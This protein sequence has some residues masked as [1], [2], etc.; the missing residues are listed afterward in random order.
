MG[1]T[2]HR[3]VV[4]SERGRALERR[5]ARCAIA[6]LWVG[7]AT[8]SSGCF[9]EASA[10]AYGLAQRDELRPAW[11]VGIST[12]VYFDPGPVRVQVGAGG[13]ALFDDEPGEAEATHMASGGTLRLDVTA[14]SLGS[15][16][17]PAAPQLRV[18][19]L[20]A[21][22]T[23]VLRRGDAT[24]QY[25]LEPESWALLG[26]VGATIGLYLGDLGLFASVG[27]AVL[28]SEASSLGPSVATGAQARLTLSYVPSGLGA[29]FRN[30]YDPERTDEELR[31][32]RIQNERAA[33]DLARRRLEQQRSWQEEQRR[34]RDYNLCN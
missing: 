3:G 23:G 16:Y 29:L 31:Q 1:T 24:S 20:A 19:A 21:G 27:P 2:T 28:V 5:L 22:S 10:G 14:A 13:E 30:G 11:S 15:E 26:Y 17:D 34:C 18:T 25:E 6:A 32:M 9:V 4:S 33:G 12:G 7:L 8:L